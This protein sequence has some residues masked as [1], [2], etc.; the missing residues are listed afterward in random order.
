M[1]LPAFMNKTRALL[2]VINRSA[3]NV[4]CRNKKP[5]PETGTG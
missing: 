2:I 1:E 4:H 5:A 3:P